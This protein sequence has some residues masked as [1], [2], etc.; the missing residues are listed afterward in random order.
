M[1]ES[2]P[3]QTKKYELENNSLCNQRRS[4][5]NL[6]IIRI[7]KSTELRNSKVDFRVKLTPNKNDNKFLDTQSLAWFKR[8]VIS[9]MNHY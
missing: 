9:N 8:E 5:P 3:N 1:Y 7:G 4:K 2:Q 6:N